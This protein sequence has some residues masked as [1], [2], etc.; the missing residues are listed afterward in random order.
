MS[1]VVTK[2]LK[3]AS[4]QDRSLIVGSALS[5]VPRSESLIE[6]QEP[7]FGEVVKI[8]CENLKTW[9]PSFVKVIRGGQIYVVSN[10]DIFVD[11]EKICDIV[12]TRAKSETRAKVRFYFRA[13]CAVIVGAVIGSFV[14]ASVVWLW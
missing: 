5:F 1:D 14:I 8:C 4:K 9:Q 6:S 7:W 2:Y 13:S 11:Y 3:A 12:Q 10:N